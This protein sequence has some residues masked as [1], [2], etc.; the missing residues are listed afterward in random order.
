MNAPDS[1]G[2]VGSEIERLIALVDEAEDAFYRFGELSRTDVAGL[3][4]S[5]P[6]SDRA[7]S[8]R[9][10]LE[11]ALTDL[12][13]RAER[14][15]RIEVAAREVVERTDL[16]WTPDPG[17][18][19][20]DNGMAEAFRHRAIVALAAVLAPDGVTEDQTDE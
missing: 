2:S 17:R 7:A 5:F 15:V 9:H 12:V 16:A 18:P 13:A 6:V 10:A 20:T 11:S 4:A 3:L 19:T 1:G 8:A 14:G